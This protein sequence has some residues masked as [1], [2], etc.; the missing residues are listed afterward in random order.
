MR[1]YPARVRVPVVVVVVLLAATFTASARAHGDPITDTLLIAPIFFPR[2]VTV[3]DDL[4]RR[5]TAEVDRAREAGYSLKVALV[6][7]PADLGPRSA[8]YGKPGLLATFV[9]RDLAGYFY[10]SVLV[11]MPSGV[12]LAPGERSSELR[13]LRAG[14]GGNGLAATAIEAV[15]VL[16]GDAEAKPQDDGGGSSAWGDRF[17]IGAAVLLAAVLVVAVRVARGRRARRA[18]AA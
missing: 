1:G 7:A 6:S 10:G 8:F 11:V 12:G 15:R 4:V 2:E 3:S 17:A 5:L 16:A 18:P 13:N 14:P 9:S